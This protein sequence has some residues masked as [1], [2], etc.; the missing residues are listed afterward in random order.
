[1]NSLMFTNSTTEIK[2][3]NVLKDKNSQLTSEEL[4]K[5]SGPISIRETEFAV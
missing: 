4:G 2:W 3:P 1:M 5:L